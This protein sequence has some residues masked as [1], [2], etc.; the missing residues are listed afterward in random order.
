MSAVMPSLGDTI[1]GKYRIEAILGRGGMGVVYAARH[2]ISER[3]V[4][5][6][7]MEAD[8]QSEPDAL[9]RFLRE[10][11]AMGRIDHPNVVGVLDVGT[12]GPVAYLVM[13]IL[14]GES[15]R[16]RMEREGKLSVETALALLL[17][18][19][20][21]VEA[22]HRAGVVHRD[23]KPEN[24]FVA[25]TAAGTVTKVLDFGISKLAEKEVLGQQAKQLTKS[26]HVIG[27]PT[28]MAPEQIH[29]TTVDART[30]V[31]A[32]ATI[33]YEMLSGRTPF[34]A[35]SFGAL[36]VAIATEPYVP[37]DPALVPPNVARLVHKGLAKEPKD[38]F[39]SVAELARALEPFAKGAS[40][41]EPRGPSL[42]P[43]APIAAAPLGADA[44]LDGATSQDRADPPTARHSQPPLPTRDATTPQKKQAPLAALGRTMLAGTPEA[45]ASAP[46]PATPRLPAAVP[47]PVRL[48]RE[49]QAAAPPSEAPAPPSSALA[50]SLAAV[51]TLLAV[52]AAAWTWQAFRGP[53]RS[54]PPIASTAPPS[55][56]PAPSIAPA[57]TIPTGHDPAPPPS[58]ASTVTP[59]SRPP[60]SAPSASVRGHHAA[61]PPPSGAGTGSEVTSPPSS[62]T[63]AAS[64]S[65][66]IRR[67]DF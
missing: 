61:H 27:T 40:F 47:T 1:A 31:W 54:A 58:V 36:L 53:V 28:Y 39:Q 12:E 9:E 34:E 21:G 8:L 4:A 63:P 29:G 30:D 37:L 32:L 2:A 3:R 20:E 49:A 67:E 10:A 5:V 18:A 6:K 17:P 7:W 35:D 59:P 19:M 48:R 43:G 14:R 65:G 25:T 56:A 45:P 11:R 55:A 33:L 26:G 66:S 41:R 57:P 44:P 38:R 50:W 46:L 42:L 51:M 15:L 52:V 24:L 60:A 16:A 22:A 64:R 62:E 13:E 23:L